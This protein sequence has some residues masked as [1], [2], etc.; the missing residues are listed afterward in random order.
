MDAAE[1]LIIEVGHAGITT[2]RLAQEAGVNHGLVHY[3]FGS[4]ENLLA[5]TLDRFTDRLIERQRAMY[6][7][8]V[9]FIEKW[10]TAM[11][12]M[13]IDRESGYQKIWLEMHA[14]AWNDPDLRERVAR[15]TGEWRAVVREALEEAVREYA[16]DPA[17]TPCTALTALVETFSLG[18]I[19]ERH[20]GVAEGHRELIEEIDRWLESLGKGKGDAR[21]ATRRRR[22]RRA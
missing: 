9:P 21:T 19:L 17:E 15:V 2:R 12:Y 4:M 10:R 6:A 8:D 11:S 22:V 20:V 18:M 7:A 1:R 3:Y 14:L 16:L 5:E 13:D